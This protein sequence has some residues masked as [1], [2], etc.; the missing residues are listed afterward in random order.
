MHSEYDNL[1]PWVIT[2]W[3]TIVF[4]ILYAPGVGN[5]SARRP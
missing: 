4:P 3:A 2:F 5:A 1:P